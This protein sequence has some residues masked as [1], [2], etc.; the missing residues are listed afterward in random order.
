V[1]DK[2]AKRRKRGTFDRKEVVCAAGEAITRSPSKSA[3]RKTDMEKLI[4]EFLQYFFVN[5][6]KLE[7]LCTHLR[8]F[9]ILGF[10]KV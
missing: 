6:S 8:K 3:P 10:N 5:G 2:R 1:R 7:T 9:Y 4:V